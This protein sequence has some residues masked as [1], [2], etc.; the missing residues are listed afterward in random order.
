MKVKDVVKYYPKET[1]FKVVSGNGKV[2]FK[3]A[4]K[5]ISRLLMY[6]KVQEIEPYI[7][8]NNKV[9]ICLII[10]EVIV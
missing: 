9:V 3:G 6:R 1:P 5:K 4:A 2:V 10:K 8:E 7:D